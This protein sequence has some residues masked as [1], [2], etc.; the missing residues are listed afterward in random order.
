MFKEFKREYVKV[1]DLAR[2]TKSGIIGAVRFLYV[3]EEIV[4]A[5]WKPLKTNKLIFI[6]ADKLRAG[7]YRAE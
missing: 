3:E 5:I 6:R 2:N 1:N 7:R 4:Y